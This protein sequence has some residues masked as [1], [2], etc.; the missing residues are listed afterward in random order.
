MKTHM[1]IYT[2]CAAAALTSCIDRFEPAGADASLAGIL[3]V[4]GTIAEGIT[5]ITLSRSKGMDA[6]WTA[7]PAVDGAALYVACDDGSTSAP[8]AY[9]GD[10]LYEIETGLLDS[11]KQYRLHIALDGE[12]YEST[13]LAPLFTPVIDSIAW[14]KRGQ[15]E[16]V[17]ITVSTHDDDDR[18]PYYRWTYEEDWEFKSELY[19]AAGL[20]TTIDGVDYY[21]I[22]DLQTSNNVYYCWGTGGS[23]GFILGSSDRLSSNVISHRKLIEIEPS[24]EKLSILYRVSVTQQQIRKEAY[25]Y[26]MNL[27][28]NVTQT[29][30][31]FSHIPAETEGNIRCLTRP[32]IPV[33]GYVE[34][35]T[36]ARAERFFPEPTGLYEPPLSQCPFQIVHRMEK[37]A[38]SSIYDFTQAQGQGP[39]PYMAV[40][41]ALSYGPVQCLDCTSRGTKNKPAAWPTDHL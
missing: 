24:D 19:S 37:G 9:R 8:S 10:G 11:G 33:V 20:V 26:F 3:V 14:L 29:G 22:Y 2:L 4:E 6:E 40:G 15:G 28:K 27:Q 35:S 21:R 18:P 30:S 25:D 36:V 13:Y 16:P 38:Y 17:Y 23:A 7:G 34:V 1:H 39:E 12:E 5:A 31:I 32:D 41:E